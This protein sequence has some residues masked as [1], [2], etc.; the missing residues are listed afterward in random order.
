MCLASVQYLQMCNCQNHS[1]QD[2][3]KLLFHQHVGLFSK[4][5]QTDRR[6]NIA[7]SAINEAYVWNCTYWYSGT[8]SVVDY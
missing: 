4:Y 7:L 8:A 1:L 2:V 6:S 3:I 5:V